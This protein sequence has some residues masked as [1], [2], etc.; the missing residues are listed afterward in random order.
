MPPGPKKRW[1]R[2][3]AQAHDKSLS[4]PLFYCF[5]AGAGAGTEASGPVVSG[6]VGGKGS[7]RSIFRAYC[8][9]LSFSGSFGT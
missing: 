9:W 5:S 7:P 8:S 2:S 4:R 3:G 6:T 1:R